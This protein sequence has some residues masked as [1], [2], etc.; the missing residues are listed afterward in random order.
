MS[1]CRNPVRAELRANGKRR[2]ELSSDGFTLVELM[3]AFLIFGMLAAAGVA[4][5]GFSVRAQAAQGAKL[6]DLAG[7]TRTVSVLSADCAEAVARP[8]R[9]ANGALLPAFTGDAGSGAIPMLRMVRGGW[10]NLDAEPRPGLQK[11]EYRVAGGAL[12]RV[13]YPQ[14]DG[15]APLTPAV[16]LTHVRAARMR[17]RFAG[18]WSDRWDGAGGVAL[19]QALELTVT[20]DNG[21]TVR[22]LAL[23]G[24][25][26]APAPPTR[27]P[28]VGP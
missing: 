23:V 6:D 22:Q 15:A 8:T 20:R 5:L 16:L 10:S 11:V 2:G 1:V 14:L 4:V 25:G 3:V 18:A 28:H 21:T 12:E 24:T 9:N 7:L 26:Y 13:A 17:Y 27:T 19:P